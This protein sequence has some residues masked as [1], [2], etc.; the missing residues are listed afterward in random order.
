MKNFK[1]MRKFIIVT[2]LFFTIYS[3]VAQRNVEFTS[4][5]FPDQ[6]RELRQAIRSIEEG[7]EMIEYENRYAAALLLYKEAYELNPN[8]A[9]LNYKV[10][11]CYYKSALKHDCLQYFEKAYQ[12]NPQ[13]DRQILYYLGRG[14][15]LNYQ[16]DKADKYYTDYIR[17]IRDRSEI[18]FVNHLKAQCQYA[19]RLTQDTLK[20]IIITNV[21]SGI[22]TEY[23]EYAPLIT[24]DGTK[25]FFTSRRENTTGGN[26]AEDGQYFE[27]IY[28]ST[29]LGDG[30][31][32]AE[33]I[34]RPINQRVHSAAVGLSPDGDRLFVYVDDNGG[35][36]YISEF[37][38]NRWSRPECIGKN[39]N[40]PYHE[41]K[42][43]ISADGQTLYFISDRPDLSIGGRD[44]FY[45]NLDDRG[46]WGPPTN[47]GPT[48]NT[49]YDEVDIF[50]H[51]DGE[52]MFFSSA[53]H[54]S[55]G[56]L[57]IFRTS[58]DE[59]GNW[60]RPENV[61]FPINTPGDDTFF[62][63]TQ[64]ATIGYF[65]SIRPGGHG[66][67]DI[68]EITFVDERTFLDIYTN[69]VEG[70]V[71]DVDTREPLFADIEIFDITN[72]SVY[73]NINSDSNTGEYTTEVK[74]GVEYRMLVT[75]PG[76]IPHS[77]NFEFS[78][79]T[80]D[81]L[82]IIDVDLKRKV[83]TL[84]VVV[85][86]AFTKTFLEADLE[87]VDMDKNKVHTKA[88]TNS[89]TGDYTIELTEGDNYQ[90]NVNKQG[91]L[92]QS[93]DI[94]F[95][96]L[97]EKQHLV[98][99][100][101][102][103]EIKVGA[104]VILKNIFF[105]FDRATL[106]RESFI[107]L[108]KVVDLL[109]SEPNL[110]IEIS[111]HTDNK[112]SFEY[113]T[114]LSRGRAKAVVDYLISKGISANRLTFEGYSFSKPIASNAT[115]EGR[116]LNRRVEFKV[117]DYE[118]VDTFISES[119]IISEDSDYVAEVAEV[120]TPAPT[121]E[122]ETEVAKVVTPA[123][124]EEPE[125]EVAEVVTPTPT[126]EPET[127]VAE[128]VTPAPTEPKKEEPVRQVTAP[129]D[130]KWTIQVAASRRALSVERHF[131][132]LQGVQL[133]VGD[134]GWHRYYVGAYRTR[135]EARAAAENLKSQGQEAFIRELSFFK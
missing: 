27:D 71:R 88:V 108:N 5:N 6:R 96:E 133:H 49:E 123:P 32:P 37:D 129:A 43:T 84:K 66:L 99:Y 3:T 121:E 21:G 105:D 94:K 134:D 58:R 132:N 42:A 50:F 9:K 56:G 114:R 30:W 90:I 72:D 109:T 53:G 116:Q 57:D 16:F 104:T 69:T 13:V 82:L 26:I 7:D 41:S 89:N 48:I 79:I 39:I 52:T 23:N 8:N 47:L 122:P 44:I 25:M 31:T 111:G 63:T 78:S 81:Q 124:T 128:V 107:E 91:Y 15:H 97:Q 45:S 2:V 118:G 86:D 19:K 24:A 117:T 102:L 73:T 51:P 77:E 64:C 80:E 35:D 76:Y 55:L 28:M 36:I 54:N 62:V 60:N 93:K 101:D 131:P 120:V 110:K 12:L 46:E 113:N 115:D 33:N 29:N 4:A 106:R 22:N 40:T 126:E 18:S 98:V 67:L 17:T 14:Y 92:N 83:N 127:E 20:N 85:R 65:A 74:S 70:V 10:G 119:Q 61:G 11:V 75:K 112:G 1:L 135:A 95:A 87:L 103:E 68:Y 38:G 130:A 34:G 125:T 100:F 59:A